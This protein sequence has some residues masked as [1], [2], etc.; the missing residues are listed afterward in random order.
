MRLW[1]SSAEKPYFSCQGDNW[2]IGSS[3]NCIP[4]CQPC[5]RGA[6]VSNI[7]CQVC[8]PLEMNH[9]KL[10]LIFRVFRASS[11]HCSLT[12]LDQHTR[13]V[14]PQVVSGRECWA[15]L[16]SWGFWGSGMAIS[17]F[18]FIQWSLL[19]RVDDEGALVEDGTD[20]GVLINTELL[21]GT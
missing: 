2:V 17:G 15:S 12:K 3:W 1:A 13:A 20:Q 9:L 5:V 14:V 18:V 16:G 19:C 7:L 4:G 21:I 8:Y 11:C 6:Q 10:F